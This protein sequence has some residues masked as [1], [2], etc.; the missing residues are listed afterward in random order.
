M[1]TCSS[2]LFLS[3][4]FVIHSIFWAWAQTQHFA[5]W[6]HCFSPQIMLR[7]KWSIAI[8]IFAVKLGTVQWVD[9]LLQTPEDFIILKELL[10]FV[11]F[12]TGCFSRVNS[13]IQIHSVLRSTE[14]PQVLSPVLTVF[15]TQIILSLNYY[16]DELSYLEDFWINRKFK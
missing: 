2:I 12:F 9:F 4:I 15:L 11:R 5:S 6:G 16:Y 8:L 7:V 1:L 10:I 3:E 14:P 13:I